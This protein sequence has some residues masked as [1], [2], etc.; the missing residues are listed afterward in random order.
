MRQRN[1]GIY[2]YGLPCFMFRRTERWTVWEL[3][4]AKVEANRVAQLLGWE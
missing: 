1:R 2:R 3:S 4:E